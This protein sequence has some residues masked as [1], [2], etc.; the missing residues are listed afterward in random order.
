MQ[1]MSGTQPEGHG[2][3]GL[4]ATAPTLM[5]GSPHT[6]P[7]ITIASTPTYVTGDPTGGAPQGIQGAMEAHRRIVGE[8]HTAQDAQQA[9]V[10]AHQS[11]YQMIDILNLQVRDMA[12]QLEDRKADDGRTSPAGGAPVRYNRPPTCAARRLVPKPVGC[13]AHWLW[14][15]AHLIGHHSH[16]WGGQFWTK[17]ERTAT[18]VLKRIEFAD[19]SVTRLGCEQI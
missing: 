15:G 18:F 9:S 17:G 4:P 7:S 2:A 5:G 10:L 3:M 14:N 16:D 19:D 1:T 11:S 13:Q 6:P 12:K 8:L